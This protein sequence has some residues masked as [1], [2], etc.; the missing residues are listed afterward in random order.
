MVEDL[1][2]KT[3]ELLEV[4]CLDKEKSKQAHRSYWKCKCLAC[5]KIV[6]VRKEFLKRRSKEL[7]S[8]GCT[9]NNALKD[10]VGNRYGHLTV[11][12][13]SNQKAKRGGYPYWNCKC[14]CGAITVVEGTQLRYGRVL[15]C[16][17]CQYRYTP[18]NTGFIDRT[19][20]KYGFLT[21]LE[22]DCEN[23]Y[24]QNTLWRCKCDCGNIVSVL[25]SHLVSGHTISCGCIKS[26]GE[27]TIG[28]ILQEKQITYIT[29]Y[30][31]K[32]FH[33]SETNGTPKFDFALFTKEEK[34]ACLIEYNGK[35]HYRAVDFFG[36]EE[37][38]IKAQKRDKE[39][40]EYC[41]S[42]NIPLEIISYKDYDNLKQILLKLIAKYNLS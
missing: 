37:S 40:I 9:N 15:T 17:K 4:V 6:S 14:D 27:A 2:G 23:Q 16:G 24:N 32:D 41:S 30:S 7:P 26:K 42:H 11:L 3:F 38:F 31:I 39:K 22:R 36:G 29:Q 33:F 13:H 18:Q 21:V 25:N 28:M 5:G 19:G 20:K 35:Q 8:C 12:S 10:E 1:T 34:L